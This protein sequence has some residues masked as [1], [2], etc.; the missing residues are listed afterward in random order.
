MFQMGKRDWFPK[1]V[2]D[3]LRAE[4]EAAASDENDLKVVEEDIHLI[5]AALR[6]DRCVVSLDEKA[7]AFFARASRK[8]AQIR[9]VVWVNPERMEEKPLDWLENGAQAEEKRMLGFRAGQC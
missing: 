3:N 1:T 2:D 7:R 8:V 9:D 6:T 5:E 4:I